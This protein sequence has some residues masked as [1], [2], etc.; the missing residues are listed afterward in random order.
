MKFKKL[1]AAVL[2]AAIVL[3]MLAVMFTFSVGASASAVGI[4]E[5]G[6]F[7][8][9]ASWRDGR[10]ESDTAFQGTHVVKPADSRV[11]SREFNVL[12]NNTYTVGVWYR[13]PELETVDV[14]GVTSDT[15]AAADSRALTASA[16]IEAVSDW[17][18]T[19]FTF[20]SG[21]HTKFMAALGGKNIEIDAMSV[22]KKT[23]S[24]PVVNP[25]FEGGAFGWDQLNED[26]PAVADATDADSGMLSL[27]LAN[28]VGTGVSQVITVR[29]NMYYTATVKYK[30]GGASAMW[31]VARAGGVITSN[32]FIVPAVKFENSENWT[33]ST[34]SFNAGD[35]SRVRLAVL[36]GE[37]GA[38]SVDSVELKLDP[39]KNILP[40]GD[41]ENEFTDW[42]RDNTDTMTVAND[43]NDGT[44]SVHFAVNKWW[45]SLVS[46]PVTAKA[47]KKYVAAITVKGKMSWGKYSVSTSPRNT[48]G[49]NGFIGGRTFDKEIKEW[50]TFYTNAFSFDKDTPVYFN[51]KPSD[52][53]NT[54]IFM[55][56][57]AIY[58][59]A[60]SGYEPILKNGDFENET[61]GWTVGGQNVFS[62]TSDAL[63]GEGALHVGTS[64]Q[65]PYIWQTFEAKAGK[66][67]VATL[68][69]KG[70]PNWAMWAVATKAGSTEPV[71]KEYIVGAKETQETSEYVSRISAVFSVEKDQT[72]YFN[73]KATSGC[74]LTFDDIYILEIDADSYVINGACEGIIKPFTG[75]SD[76]FWID[77]T[78]H[79]GGNSSIAV[80]SG[81]YQKLSQA[82]TLEANTNYE[83]SFW[84]KGTVPSYSAWA[85]SSDVSLSDGDVFVKGKLENTTEWKQVKAVFNPGETTAAY[86]VFQNSR[87]SVFNIDDIRL[88]KTDKEAEPATEKVNPYFVG[89]KSANYY[90]PGPFIAEPEDNLVKNYSFENELSDD[91]S[92]AANLAIGDLTIVTEA[93]N[94][95]SGSKS[96]KI[97][98]GNATAESS[99]PVTLKKNTRYLVTVFIKAMGPYEDPQSHL[100]FGIADTDTGNFLRP[101]DL[102]SESARTYIDTR[103][104][105]PVRDN[106]WHLRS[107]EFFSGDSENLI[108]KI[109]GNNIT[110]YFDDLYIFESS[111]GVEWR[112]ELQQMK[113]PYVTDD[114]PALLGIQNEEDNLFEN[115]FMD[116]PDDAYWKDTN[117]VVFGRDLKIIDS[118]HSIHRYSMY[119][120]NSYYDHPTK[121]YYIKWVDVEPNTEYTF[122]ASYLIESKGEAFIGMI[123]GYKLDKEIYAEGENTLYPSII[124]NYD[125]GP[126]NFDP[127]LNWKNV[128]FSFNTAESN[129]VGFVV[130]AGSGSLYV[131]DLRL[132]ETKNAA[133]LVE[134][135]DTTPKTLISNSSD[136]K[137]SGGK[138]LPK[139]API[140]ISDVVSKLKNNHYVKVY[141]SL[142]FVITDYSQYAATGMEFRLMN[143]P[144]IRDRATFIAP[145][146]VN[147]DGVA[148]GEDTRLIV[149]H[150]TGENPLTDSALDAADFNRDGK[151]NLYDLNRKTGS[152]AAKK[153]QFTLEGPEKF[154]PGDDIEITL[155]SGINN[156]SAV[157][158]E[159]TFDSSMLTFISASLDVS[160]DWTISS[161]EDDGKISFTAADLS[162]KASADKGEV[163]MTFTFT[164]GRIT[165]YEDAAV[166]L[167]KLHAI[168]GRN[169]IS[170]PSTTWSL[171]TKQNNGG[172]KTE[173]KIP[174]QDHYTTH[175]TPITST[176]V[177][178]GNRLSSLSLE[179][180]EIVPAFDPEV[181]E[182]TA[183]V[184]FSV[185]KVTVNAVPATPGATVTITGDTLEYVGRNLV[186]V[187][188]VSPEGL[189]R[190]Y[191]ILVTREAPLEDADG[192]AGESHRMPTW[193]IVLLC[194]AAAVLLAIIVLVIILIVAKRKEKKEVAAAAPIAQSVES[195]P[196]E[197]THP[198]E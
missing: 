22:V 67:Y 33:E 105:V 167:S 179:E 141:D 166:T 49:G 62:A 17:T 89:E 109:S 147:G 143:G 111:K 138:I 132:F 57:A 48:D 29:P 144:V 126:D 131:D 161:T 121:N 124:K 106:E 58:E 186:S 110:A 104:C 6:G 176:T 145:G 114:S 127:Y 74:D 45:S 97:A 52:S 59:I 153:A 151:V 81:E 77:S 38:L 91:P 44:K 37:S 118:E 2:A 40:N 50:T 137:I 16:K 177:K 171:I 90:T 96:L 108:F 163:L 9:D 164:V 122:S 149:N 76:Y 78:Q 148:N 28:G 198:E 92:D 150:L 5:D 184:P 172:G 158:G 3:S 95:Y 15:S 85:V 142:G 101:Q 36:L 93:G 35:V 86:V 100:T 75:S 129:R 25:S 61:S 103:Q 140:R 39:S 30:G 128:G 27:K 8:S 174:A 188:V 190:T 113:K 21:A 135:I 82:I 13:N 46:K 152:A 175:T 14:F 115:A 84:Y 155:K 32:S 41:F 20:T 87:N 130:C 70:K 125:C 43:A 194:C 169:L 69:Y 99:V 56:S 195:A 120:T 68:A 189:K 182:Y 193:L 34:V 64:A 134:A 160:G 88:V 197:E 19:E 117:G 26:V 165:K 42:D 73:I 18:Y 72:L 112:S 139:K 157:S 80:G 187:R 31:G 55:D 51:F 168:N 23:T 66:K 192:E 181:K 4:L 107:F 24:N 146:D 191:K 133:K 123:S 170:S 1:S 183:T 119:Y 83:F 71:D 7:E 178:A 102:Q 79:H 94:A 156:L 173:I 53:N 10:A 65:Y 63:T 162:G 116:E 60:D 154:N 136:I 11:F 12:P 185:E 196:S 159:I 180:A 54:D 98:A 47:G